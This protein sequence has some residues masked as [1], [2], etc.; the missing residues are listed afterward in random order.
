MRG[1]GCVLLDYFFVLS[2]YPVKFVSLSRVFWSHLDSLVIQAFIKP[3]KEQIEVLYLIKYSSKTAAS[4]SLKFFQP[5]ADPFML[6]LGVVH[7]DNLPTS[8]TGAF[9]RS[10]IVYMYVFL[11]VTVSSNDGGKIKKNSCSL[12]YSH[13]HT[14]SPF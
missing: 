1:R 2:S 3:M 4:C 9:Q 8:C 11:L 6:K 14:H 12:W 5:T 10:Q 13:T 7:Q